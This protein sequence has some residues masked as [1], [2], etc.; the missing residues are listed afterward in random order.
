MVHHFHGADKALDLLDSQST[1]AIH[2]DHISL[3]T[4][5][6]RLYAYV[7]LPAIE[8]VGYLLAHLVIYMLC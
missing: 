8:Y 1:Q 7:A 3:H 2:G 4:D 5:D 6:S